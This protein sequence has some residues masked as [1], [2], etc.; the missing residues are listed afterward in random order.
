MLFI[1]I[2]EANQVTS[3]T[4]EY[5]WASFKSHKRFKTLGDNQYLTL[6]AMLSRSEVVRRLQYF[7]HNLM[8]VIEL[9]VLADWFALVECFK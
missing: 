4:R 2:I 3:C 5:F 8:R 6:Q 1:D 7:L 9:G